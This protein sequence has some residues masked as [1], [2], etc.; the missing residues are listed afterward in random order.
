[1]TIVV[2]KSDNRQLRSDIPVMKKAAEHLAADPALARKF[3]IENGFMT[4]KSG[5]LTKPISTNPAGIV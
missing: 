2:S 3:L 5:K 1:M 4:P